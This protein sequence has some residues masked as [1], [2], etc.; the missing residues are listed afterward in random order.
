MRN[1]IIVGWS[2]AIMALIF[3]IIGHSGTH[4]LSW[5]RNQISTYAAQAPHDAWITASMLLSCVALL[6]VSL[7]VSRYK[8]IGDHSLI[9][10][11]PVIIGAT[12]SG[13]LV[14]AYYEETA[15]T[16]TML[17][18]SGFMSIRLQS[19]H[20]AGLLVFFYGSVLLVLILGA[21]VIAFKEGVRDKLIGLG[22]FVLGP[23]S[24]SL[25]GTSWPKLVGIA[26]PS[27]G[28]KQRMALLCLWLAMVLVLALASNNTPRSTAHRDTAHDR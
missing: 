4:G 18:R 8:M 16:I 13:L 21:F 2:S 26:G 27:A 20:D 12:I 22:I 1:T 5:F 9:H 7:L 19:F 11:V 24:F 15:K 14:L 10:V 6:S 17:K 25:M 23:A 28:I 3:M